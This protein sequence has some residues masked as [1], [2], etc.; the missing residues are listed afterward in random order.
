MVFLSSNCYLQ[1]K[2]TKKPRI[3]YNLCR[4]TALKKQPAPAVS[5]PDSKTFFF[6]NCD[7]YCVG[8]RCDVST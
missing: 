5:I 8:Y 1:K 6:F 3:I 4:N 7:L 2:N